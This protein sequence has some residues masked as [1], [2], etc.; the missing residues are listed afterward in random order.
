MMNRSESGRRE[1]E[2]ERRI[3][4]LE[5]LADSEQ[6][7]S[8]ATLRLAKYLANILKLDFR[9]PPWFT[10]YPNGSCHGG[11]ASTPPVYEWYNRGL[12]TSKGPGFPTSK[13]CGW[14]N[15]IGI[16][17]PNDPALIWKY[18]VY[19]TYRGVKQEV[20][21]YT[22]TCNG[23]V[24]NPGPVS[25]PNLDVNDY[26]IFDWEYV[27]ATE[28]NAVM[29]ESISSNFQW[30]DSANKVTGVRSFL[31]GSVTM[32]VDEPF[33][34]SGSDGPIYYGVNYGSGCAIGDSSYF[35]TPSKVP[36][37][38]TSSVTNLNTLATISP[39]GTIKLTGLTLSLP[40]N[41]GYSASE[42]DLDT[43][44]LALLAF[45]GDT[46][47]F[48]NNGNQCLSFNFR[49]DG[50]FINHVIGDPVN[51]TYQGSLGDPS[52]GFGAIT[53]LSGGRWAKDT[54]KVGQTSCDIPPTIYQTLPPTVGI[55]RPV[56]DPASNVVAT[57]ATIMFRSRTSETLPVI[58]N[59]AYSGAAAK[60]QVP[61]GPLP[62]GFKVS[63]TDYDG[64]TNLNGTPRYNAAFIGSPPRS[65]RAVGTWELTIG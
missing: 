55:G 59:I 6:V 40:A 2:L 11:V 4:R 19:M 63:F 24:I 30:F 44:R 37:T 50:S 22:W 28:V 52:I 56:T 62:P 8:D 27:K 36:L 34:I 9:M 54:P 42:A 58:N 45:V 21:S 18:V 49:G 15:P 14:A 16:A 60:I 39:K 46:F 29:S 1:L 47:Q 41:G 5:R 43:A 26:V 32:T 3:F 25:I 17:T 48:G 65:M 31:G 7:R 12:Y 51:A 38:L 33:K 23:W 10:G 64:Y 57:G 20:L 13:G 35:K 61:Y 53:G